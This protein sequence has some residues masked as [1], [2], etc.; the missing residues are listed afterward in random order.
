MFSAGDLIPFVERIKR[1]VPNADVW[2]YSGFTY[3]QIVRDEQRFSLL[4]LCDVLV[5]GKFLAEE[6]DESLR[7]RG[8]RNQRIIDIQK[9]KQEGNIVLYNIS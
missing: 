2:I 3:E 7:F 6:K 8:S 5:D 4:S 9:T 1:E